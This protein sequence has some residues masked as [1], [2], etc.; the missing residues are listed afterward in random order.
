MDEYKSNSNRSKEQTPPAIHTRGTIQGGVENPQKKAVIRMM[1]LLMTPDLKGA[2]D[3]A[4]HRVIGPKVKDLVMS[5]IQT[6]IYGPSGATNVDY[7]KPHQVPYSSY[8]DRQNMNYEPPAPVPQDRAAFN[9]SRLVLDSKA[10]CTT[11]VSE[12]RGAIGQYGLAT[13]AD[14]KG[15]LKMRPLSTDY[16]YGWKNF[17]CS[18]PIPLQDGRWLLE[19]KKPLPLE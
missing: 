13:V 2:W 17:D 4:L 8:Y 3:H 7:S 10:D 6:F 19:I 11:V 9:P 5:V 15:V 1:D 18:A 16:N 14:L 12:M